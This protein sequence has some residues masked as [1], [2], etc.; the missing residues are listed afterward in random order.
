MARA[1]NVELTDRLLRSAGAQQFFTDLAT[2]PPVPSSQFHAAI[3]GEALGEKQVEEDG[4][5]VEPGMEDEPEGR[6]SRM[7]VVMEEDEKPAEG[8]HFFDSDDDIVD[9][10]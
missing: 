6:E 5:N 4:F 3:S 7:D 9:S 1:G 10:D 8:E 2:F